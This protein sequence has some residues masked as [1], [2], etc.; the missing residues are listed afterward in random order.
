MHS[1]ALHFEK[2]DDEERMEIP[3]PPEGNLSN[4][5]KKKYSIKIKLPK[6]L[7]KI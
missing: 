5:P 1:D 4:K 6:Q 2:E 7:C 3:K